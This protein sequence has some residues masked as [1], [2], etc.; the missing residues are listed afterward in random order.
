VTLKGQGR[1]PIIFEAPYFDNSATETGRQFPI[2]TLMP[3]IISITLQGA[4]EK[5]PLKFFAVFSATV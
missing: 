1:D 2:T 4:A 5:S 3:V